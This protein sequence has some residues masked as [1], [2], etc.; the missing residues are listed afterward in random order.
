MAASHS[1]SAST[2]TAGW[3]QVKV[4]GTTSISFWAWHLKSCHRHPGEEGSR[5]TFADGTMLMCPATCDEVIQAVGSGMQIYEAVEAQKKAAEQKVFDAEDRIR[6]TE[7]AALPAAST[8]DV[9]L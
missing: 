8:F 9:R 4:A 5:L 6:T 3:I 2:T 7:L 1:V